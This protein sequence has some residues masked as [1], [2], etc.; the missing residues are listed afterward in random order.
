MLHR[1]A[2]CLHPGEEC[3]LC[4]IT[5]T[6]PINCKT[7]PVKALRSQA[8]RNDPQSLGGQDFGSKSTCLEHPNVASL[9]SSKDSVCNEIQNA[10]T[11]I[12]NAAQGIGEA[13][14]QPT[15]ASGTLGGA[16][17]DLESAIII[18]PLTVREESIRPAL[19]KRLEAIIS[20]AALL[21]D[22]SG[23][24]DLHRER[25]ITECNVVRQALQEL[26][27]EYINNKDLDLL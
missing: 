20:G 23:T 18:D 9:K 27:S 11:A 13:K 8:R 12:S 1:G 10:L 16:L 26:L 22:S 7:L 3:L 2:L 4:R 14:V 15:S 24:R 5:T 19:E 21:A 6:E 25:I 17:D